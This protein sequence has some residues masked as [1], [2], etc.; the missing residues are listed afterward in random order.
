LAG[1][2]S[3]SL[4]VEAERLHALFTDSDEQFLTSNPLFALFRG[5]QRFADQFGDYISDAYFTG[6]RAAV[7]R[8]LS[9]LQTIS[10]TRL[11]PSDLVSAE[12]FEWIARD[13]LASLSP[14]ILAASAVRPIDHKTGLHI[15]FPEASSGQSFAPFRTLADYENNLKRMDGYAIYLDRAI[16]R[17][18]QGMSSGVVQ[19]RLVV[20]NV[21]SQLDAQ[22]AS[23]VERSVFL[24]PLTR[25]PNSIADAD[26]KRLSDAYAAKIGDVVLPATRRL[27]DFLANQYR[28]VARASVGLGQMPGGAALYQQLIASQTTTDLT[29]SEIHALGLSEVARIRD[30]M[31]AI[32][33]R[34]GFTGSLSEFFEHL[35]TDLSF[36]AASIEDLTQRYQDIGKRVEA[37]LPRLFNVVPKTA[38]EILP[39]PALRER[40]SAGGDYQPGAP[41][42][43]RPGIF[44]FNTYDLP[45]RSTTGTETLYLHEAQPGHH[46]QFMLAI[47]NAALPAFQ[48][49]GGNTAF[50]EGWALYT[51]SLGDELGMFTDPYQR[52][53]HL[54][55]EMLR[56]LRLV[57]DTGLHAYGWTFEQAIQYMLDNSATSRTAATSEVERYIANPGQAL[58]YKVGQIR[59]RALRTRAEQALRSDFDVKAFHTQILNDGALPLTVLEAKL[60]RWIQ[61]ELTKVG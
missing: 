2:R 39:T 4:S 45:S 42:G 50:V 44:Y 36:Q 41:D 21:I 11:S 43:S 32:K 55:A 1:D 53:G 25:F 8:D 22:L 34:V 3:E 26:R 28:P 52:Q 58:A 18:C 9:T 47:E 40:T 16:E 33:T 14:E 51:E 35:R 17:F 12:A 61:N 27:R 46:F 10:H 60:D 57:V 23:G 38:L 15:R 20:D 30:E 59:I 48:R 31:E 54:D 24:R 7:E 49:F 6:E 29:P 19:P 13:R 56:A 5:D 37:A